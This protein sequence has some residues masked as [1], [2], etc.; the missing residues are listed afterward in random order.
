MGGLFQ[1]ED[2]I[3]QLTSFGHIPQIPVEDMTWMSIILLIVF[4]AVVTVV[5]F[6][7]YNKRDIQ[8]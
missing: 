4:A 6:I 2:W 1:L 5:G 7:G 8:G 3:G